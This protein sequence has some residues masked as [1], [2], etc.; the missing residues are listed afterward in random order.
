MSQG[1]RG[2]YHRET[3]LVKL[4]GSYATVRL[5]KAV[6]SIFAMLILAIDFGQ[7]DESGGSGVDYLLTTSIYFVISELRFNTTEEHIIVRFVGTEF[8]G[9][10]KCG[11]INHVAAKLK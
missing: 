1:E 6:V 9:V 5:G 7:N 2:V 3:E 10:M 8:G 4:T 11:Y